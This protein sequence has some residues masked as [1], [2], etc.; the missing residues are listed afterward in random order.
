MGSFEN[1]D[2]FEFGRI[3]MWESKFS[4]VYRMLIGSICFALFFISLEKYKIP[5]IDALKSSLFLGVF[6]VYLRMETD[7]WKNK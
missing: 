3:K 7:Y 2:S 1:Q 4:E 6:F 5:P